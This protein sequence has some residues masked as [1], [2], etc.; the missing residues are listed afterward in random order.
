[1]PIYEFYCRNCH[2]VFN[3]FSARINTE[4]QPAC[5]RCGLPE[6]PRKPSTFAVLKHGEPNDADVFAQFDESR[7]EDA[8]ASLLTEAE[9]TDEEDPRAMAHM[10]RRFSDLAGLKMGDRMEEMVARLEAGQDPEQLEAEMD[11]LE[12]EGDM[13]DFFKLK[14]ALDQ[15]RRRPRVDEEL[16]FL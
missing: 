14:A 15:R 9:G 2:T 4:A 8:M 7:L 5:P 3:F 13:E 12:A 1:M 10:M 6:L 11:S 16:Y